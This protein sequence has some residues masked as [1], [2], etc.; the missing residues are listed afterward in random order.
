MRRTLVNKKK[1]YPSAFLSKHFAAAFQT[2]S[3]G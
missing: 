1:R 2:I 3:V